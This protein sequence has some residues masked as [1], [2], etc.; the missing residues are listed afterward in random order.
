MPVLKKNDFK[1]HRF[2]KNAHSQT[3]FPAF[4]RKVKGVDYSR[5]KIETLDGDFIDLDW[6]LIGSKRGAII[7]HG[8]EGSTQQPYVKG[9]VKRLN[10]EGL[11]VLAWNF[12]GCGG[13]PS[14]LIRSYH[15]GKSED[16]DQIVKHVFG[17]GYEEV[18]LI[19]FSVGG[20][21]TL[22]YL[23]EK[24]PSL[25]PRLTHSIS[26][27]VPCDLKATSYQLAKPQNRAYMEWF[28]MSLRKKVKQKESEMKLFGLNTK[29]VYRVSTFEEFDN[30]FTAPLNDFKDAEDY[31]AQS[32]SLFFLSQ[33]KIPSLLVNALDDPFLTPECFPFD[34]AENNEHL[35]LETP[36]H[37]G[38][39]G[40]ISSSLIYWAEERVISFLSRSK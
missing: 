7:S 25:D 5:E 26:F 20:N 33:I 21:I 3:I 8:L 6:S 23:G 31:W 38:H 37:G 10:E 39:V 4:F 18:V 15:S 32:S 40:F 30:R 16:L 22:K 27:S 2:L 11:D 35:F 12:R 34:V 19:G 17:R 24:G 29:N 9:M 13:R 1:P 28:M 14:K 36:Q